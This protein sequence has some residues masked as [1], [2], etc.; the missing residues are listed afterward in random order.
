[1]VLIAVLIDGECMIVD[2]SV[3]DVTLQH[4]LSWKNPGNMV[5]FLDSAIDIEHVPAETDS[6]PHWIVIV[7]VT[8]KEN[9]NQSLNG[10]EVTFTIIRMMVK[11]YINLRKG[12]SI[13]E[14]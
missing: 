14:W 9:K 3:I 10:K 12:V 8:D 1:M 5:I 13:V 6:L 2:Q 11:M 7:A 4:A